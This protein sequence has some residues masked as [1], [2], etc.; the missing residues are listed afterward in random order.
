MLQDR[1]IRINNT[2][3]ACIHVVY[4]HVHNIIRRLNTV[5]I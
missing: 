2:E 4:V 1:T 3:I 5:K